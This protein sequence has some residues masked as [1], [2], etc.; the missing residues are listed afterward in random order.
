MYFEL[1]KAQ[2]WV[3]MAERD[4][5]RGSLADSCLHA[6]NTMAEVLY[7]MADP[8]MDVALLATQRLMAVYSADLDTMS[9]VLL[10]GG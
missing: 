9:A 6:E 3:T 1:A 5:M 2:K 8:R 7:A 10:V 4:L